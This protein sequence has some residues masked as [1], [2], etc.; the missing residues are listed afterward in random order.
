MAAAPKPKSAP[1]PARETAKKGA[2]QVATEQA[3][4]YADSPKGKKSVSGRAIKGGASGAATGAALGSVVPGVGTAAG[5]VVGG[6]VGAV[7]GGVSAKRE[8]KA[9]KQAGRGGGLNAHR[10]LIM[11]F[12]IC[13]IILALYPLQGDKDDE[14][15]GAWMKKGSAMCGLFLILGLIGS[16][17]KGAAK[18]AAAFGGIVTITLLVNERSVFVTIAEKFN[19]VNSESD[20][21][22][23]DPEVDEDSPGGSAGVGVGGAVTGPGTGVGNATGQAA[24]DLAGLLK[25]LK[26]NQ[27]RVYR[28]GMR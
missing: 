19:N 25:V 12:V 5:A 7:G 3:M 11:E 22:E 6:T 10:I 14:K 27:Q 16:A 8:N 28:A 13:I 9:A 26:E 20:P 18:V 1:T 15:P 23:G 2:K 21:A 17:G 4:T 24:G